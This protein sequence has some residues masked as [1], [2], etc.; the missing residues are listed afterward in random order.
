MR[1]SVA[2]RSFPTNYQP[3]HPPPPVSHQFP[4]VSYQS[5][6]ISN[7]FPPD[8]HQFRPIFPP[9]P[10]PPVFSQFPT[11]FPTSSPQVFHQFPASSPPV[12]HQFHRVPTSS[13]C[14]ESHQVH[15]Q[16][17]TSFH[18]FPTMTP[19]PPNFQPVPA[20]SPPEF[21]PFSHHASSS[22]SFHASSPPAFPTSKTR[23]FSTSSRPV[24]RQFYT[25]IRP[26]GF[27]NRSFPTSVSQPGSSASFPPVFHQFPTSPP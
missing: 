5:P 14:R 11:R 6:L 20:R 26:L 13:T 4:P 7:Q 3:V 2:N 17:P 23:K 25:K 1:P 15:R 19:V 24:H 18:Q 21:R 8:P 12:L 10:P 16:F 9:V 27:P 22:P